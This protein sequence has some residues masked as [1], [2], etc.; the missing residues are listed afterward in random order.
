V[1]FS[2]KT[3]KNNQVHGQ[4]EVSESKHKATHLRLA[5]WCQQQRSN[6]QNRSLLPNEKPKRGR[7]GYMTDKQLQDLSKIGFRVS[8]VQL[9]F[10]DRLAQL[11]DYKQLFGH[12]WIPH[13]YTGFA[14]LGNWAAKMRSFYNLHRLPADRIVKLDE[15]GFEWSRGGRSAA[16]ADAAPPTGNTAADTQG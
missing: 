5:L 1:W 14:N 15:L 3:K 11:Q 6:F 10:D 2:S 8:N 13:A 9:E 4:C 16:A 7:G 12:A